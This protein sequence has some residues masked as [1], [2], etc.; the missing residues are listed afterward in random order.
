[1]TD[2]LIVG[3][4]SAGSVL[5]ERLS[6]D[7]D[8][9]VTVVESGPAPS[10]PRV[11]AQITDALRLP[12]GAASSVVRHYASVLTDNPPRLTQIMRGAVV[13]GSGAV[14]GGYFCRGL[15]TDFDRWAVPGWGWDDVLPHFRAIETDLDFGTALHGDTGPITVRRV[16]EFDGCTASFVDAATRAGFGWIDD[17]NGSDAGAAL[18][19]GVGAVPLNI[20]GGTRVGPGGAYLKPALG[21]PNLDLR[22]DTRV[23]R[24]LFRGNRAVG[25]ACAD[26]SVL[27]ADRIVLCSGAIG[28]AHLLLLSGVGP[29]SDLEPLGVPVVAGLPVGMHTVDHPEWVLPVSWVPTHD[30][31]PLEAVLATSEGIE[32]RPYTAGFA[33]M[34]HG[35]GHDPAELPHLGVALMRPHSRGRVRLA[36]ADPSVAPVIEHRYDTVAADVDALRQGSQLA[37]ELVSRT[38]EVGEASWSTSQHLA[39]TAPMGTGPHAVVDPTCRVLGVEGLW[40]VDGSIMP[41]ITSRGPHATIAMIGHRAAEFLAA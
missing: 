5:A 17:L 21:R 13:G 20:N 37:R 22:A 12:I 41:A 16:R 39:G 27:R 18:P 10:D 28:S 29:P 6:S 31:P 2:V 19:A 24:V 33:A 11:E 1:M 8:C 7:P 36:S 4:G 14:N 26:G 40:V 23:Q 34:V 15:P 35:P 9:R 30:L 32:V 25:V 3:A 38:T